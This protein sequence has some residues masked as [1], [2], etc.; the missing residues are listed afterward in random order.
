MKGGNHAR[1]QSASD[2]EASL[3]VKAEMPAEVSAIKLVPLQCA[4][5]P[6]PAP[7]NIYRRSCD[8]Q[9]GCPFFAAELVGW[10]GWLAG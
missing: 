2:E 7:Q 8:G 4:L 9:G 3:W 6:P 10:L 5:P 1:N